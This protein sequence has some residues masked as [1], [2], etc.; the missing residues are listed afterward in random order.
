MAENYIY[1]DLTYRTPV[2]PGGQGEASFNWV[3]GQTVK[4]ALRFQQTLADGSV[5]NT[6]LDVKNIRAALGAEGARPDSGWYRLKVGHGLVSGGNITRRLDLSSDPLEVEEALNALAGGAR[7]YECDYINNALVVRRRGGEDFKISA[8]P[9]GL[10]PLCYDRVTGGQGLKR[11]S[12]SIKV[13]PVVYQAVEAGVGGNSISIEYVKKPFPEALKVE[14]FAR[15]VVAS[16]GGNV[17][18]GQIASAIGAAASEFLSFSA[19]SGENINTSSESFERRYLAGGFDGS[20]FEYAIEFFQAPLA[21]SNWLGLESPP[22]PSMRVIQQGETMQIDETNPERVVRID[23]I[24]ELKVPLDFKGTYQFFWP[25]KGLRTKTLSYLSG[26][27]D[28]EEALNNIFGQYNGSVS[29]ENPTDFIAH[30]HFED[31]FS[32]INIPPLIVEVLHS[33]LEKSLNIE[34]DLNTY[35]IYE[36]L[37]GSE[38][39]QLPFEL[40]ATLNDGQVVNLWK[41]T[42]TIRRSVLWDSLSTPPPIDWNSRAAAV[43]F[44]EFSRDQ[45]LVGQQSAYVAVIGDGASLEYVVTHNL[46]VIVGKGVVSVSVRENAAGGRQLRDDSYQVFFTNS[47]SLKIVFNHAPQSNSLAVVILGYGPSSYF[48][49]HTH[50]IDQIKTVNQNGDVSESLRNILA[51]FGGRISALENYIPRQPV[52]VREEDAVKVPPPMVPSIGEILPDLLLEQVAATSQNKNVTINSQLA[53]GGAPID[54]TAIENQKR[55][56]EAEIAKIK[57]QADAAAKAAE[58][59]AKKSAE[60]YK[61]QI[62]AEYKKKEQESGA[63]AG[64]VVS[65]FSIL[66]VYTMAGDK[67]TS[68]IFPSMR[69]VKYGMLLPAIHSIQEQ[70]VSSAPTGFVKGL[71]KNAGSSGIAIPGGGGRKS[72]VVAPGGYFACDGRAY[73]LVSRKQGTNSF[74]P[75]EMEM[76]LV[77]AVIKNYQFPINSSLQMSWALDLGFKSNILGAGYS[78]VARAAAMSGVISPS[79]VGENTA[80]SIDEVIL[81]LTRLSLSNSVSESR[82]FTL[83][84]KKTPET[85]S[86]QYIDVGSATDGGAFPDGDLLI[87]LRLEQWD[88]DDVTSAPAGQV[89]ILMPDTQISIQKMN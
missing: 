45:F 29:V 28:V 73:Y 40:E 41:T 59:A 57:A 70:E 89:S 51:S 54:G 52:I 1:A 34:L 77:K 21:F 58:E 7:D 22:V 63:A 78:L 66:G 4:Y 84:L 12:A 42:A 56:Y 69:G 81:S 80:T 60:E 11:S 6:S 39:V 2:L 37:R 15:R 46:G 14:I 30:I 86:S 13:G 71:F 82:K 62:D 36:A 64:A 18:H 68:K 47:N 3:A 10:R 72:Q 48:L 76:D 8:M 23:T 19:V 16:F 44:S 32:G 35:G 85:R 17:S 20:G 75:S 25:E 26:T 88:V 65:T 61:K 83:T 24:Q 27:S 53:T 79:P 49:N 87:T 31:G 55:L 43:S 9:D 67:K 5:S 38:S 33:P 74:Y 50:P